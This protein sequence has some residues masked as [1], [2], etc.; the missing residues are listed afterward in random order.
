MIPSTPNPAV[1]WPRTIQTQTN[2]CLLILIPHRFISAFLFLQLSLGKRSSFK[3][4]VTYRNKKQVGQ[5]M[6][7]ITQPMKAEQCKVM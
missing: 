1:T 2:S 5:C 7:G 6:T 4:N 3:I